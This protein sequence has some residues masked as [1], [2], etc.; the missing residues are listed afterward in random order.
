[1]KEMTLRELQ[2]FALEI[3]KDVHQFCTKNSIKY[4]LYGGTLLG[5]I[6]HQGFIPWDDDIDIIMPREDYDRF[7]NLYTSDNYKLINRNN[8]SSYQLAYTRVCDIKRTRYKA[9]EPC[10]KHT[11]GVWIDVFPADGCPSNEDEIPAFYLNNKA[12][13]E[14][15]EHVR[16]SLCSYSNEWNRVSQMYGKLR[17]FKRL[18]S[19]FKS[20]IYYTISGKSNT[21]IQN[22]M[23]LSR[24]YRFS[25]S[26]FWASFTCPYKHVV[27][28]PKADYSSTI[29][30]KFEDEQF[31]AMNGYDGYLR[32]VYGDY[33]ELPPKEQQVP[34]LRNWYTFYWL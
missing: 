4:S 19:L 22:L 18:V 12:L 28:N 11:T 27:Y 23:S 8:D 25:D 10:S 7:C 29:L 16:W 20:K 14:E 13:F 2:L 24:T 33:L 26:K 31:Q 30:L 6:R 21:C 9:V 17:A 3:L 15:T 1:M 34:P 5:A 32:R